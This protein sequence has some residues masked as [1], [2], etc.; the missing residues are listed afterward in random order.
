MLRLQLPKLTRAVELLR[1]DYKRH[2]Y[3][4]FEPDF[5][6]FLRNTKTA[7]D[8]HQLPHRVLEEV[9]SD[10]NLTAHPPCDGSAL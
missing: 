4:F 3:V 2:H 5:E 9:F 8:A 6:T 10:T 7:L 1:M